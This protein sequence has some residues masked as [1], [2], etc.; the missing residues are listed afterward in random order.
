MNRHHAVVLLS[1]SRA[2]LVPAVPTPAPAQLPELRQV[3]TIGCADCEDGRQFGSIQDLSIGPS[4]EI[5]VLDDGGP[6]LRLFDRDGRLLWAGAAG[7]VPG[8]TGCRFVRA[9]FATVRS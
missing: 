1:T 4:G 5:L 7:P 2:L 6:H 3:L 9:F 8:S